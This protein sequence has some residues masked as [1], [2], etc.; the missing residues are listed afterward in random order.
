MIIILVNHITEEP[1]FQSVVV[2]GDSGGKIPCPNSAADFTFYLNWT[3]Y[4]KL[5]QMCTV[6]AP[7]F[8][9]AVLAFRRYLGLSNLHWLLMMACL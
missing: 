2:R 6:D 4:Q 3:L 9:H 1:T 7:T 8:V 5:T